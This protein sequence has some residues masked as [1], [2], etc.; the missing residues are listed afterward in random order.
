MNEERD[1]LSCIGMRVVFD[2]CPYGAEVR[3]PTQILYWGADFDTLHARCNHPVVTQ[4]NEDGTTY[5]SAHPNLAGRKDHKGE[6]LTKKLAAYP[7]QF[8]EAIASILAVVQQ[9]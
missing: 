7:K 5:Q 2:Q 8:N 1:S 3:K 4:T 6:Y 9:I